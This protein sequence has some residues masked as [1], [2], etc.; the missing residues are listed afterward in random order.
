LKLRVL[1]SESPGPVTVRGLR[2]EIRVDWVPVRGAGWAHYSDAATRIAAALLA[3]PARPHATGQQSWPLLRAS[4]S[5]F[6]LRS[7]S[8]PA[9][10]LTMSCPARGTLE[11][12]LGN[13][14]RACTRLSLRRP[15]RKERLGPRAGRALDAGLKYWSTQKEHALKDSKKNL[16]QPPQGLKQFGTC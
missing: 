13:T 11:A 8:N 10:G 4:E 15:L 1:A 16:F 6:K 12:S 5:G 14:T 2:P 7:R 9:N 3:C